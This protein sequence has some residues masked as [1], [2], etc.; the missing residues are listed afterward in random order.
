MQQ[1]VTPVI[2]VNPEPRDEVGVA[3]VLV[4]AIALIGVLIVAALLVGLATGGIFILLRKWRERNSSD[5]N[6]PQAIR[7]NLSP[8][9]R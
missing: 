5:A 3:D 9:R 1:P 6:E 2:Q 4:G 8:P 7:L